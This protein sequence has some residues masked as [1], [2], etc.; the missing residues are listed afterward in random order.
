MSRMERKRFFSPPLF[1]CILFI[2]RSAL[3]VVPK[4]MAWSRESYKPRDGPH[5][6]EMSLIVHLTSV[7]YNVSW[8]T[9]VVLIGDSKTP[10]VMACSPLEEC[11]NGKGARGQKRDVLL[12]L[13]TCFICCGEQVSGTWLASSNC[14]GG[15]EADHLNTLAIPWSETYSLKSFIL[16]KILHFCGQSGNWRK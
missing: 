8:L 13:C 9:F 1:P 12:Y 7:S 10:D 3:N 14:F 6:E 11:K 4:F 15:G 2:C 16:A 5:H